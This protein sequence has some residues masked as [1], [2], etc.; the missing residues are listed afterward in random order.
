MVI[1]HFFFPVYKIWGIKYNGIN[2]KNQ[3][4]VE[5][6]KVESEIMLNGESRI[7]DYI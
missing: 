7:V 2:E 5:F 3:G 4:E 6:G 1:Y